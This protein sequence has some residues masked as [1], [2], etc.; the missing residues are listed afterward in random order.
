MLAELAVVCHV[1]VAFPCLQRNRK[2]R[3]SLSPNRDD[4]GTD[5]CLAD[6]H[7]VAPNEGASLPLGEAIV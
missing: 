1:C 3:D 5:T 4:G 2:H 7:R 6:L